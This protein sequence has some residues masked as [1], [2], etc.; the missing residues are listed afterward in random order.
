MTLL[1]QILSGLTEST[2]PS[3]SGQRFLGNPYQF[4]LYEGV[5]RSVSFGLKVVSENSN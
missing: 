4:Y 2:S 1:G 3:W 5:E